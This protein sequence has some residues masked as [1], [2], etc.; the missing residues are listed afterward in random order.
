[1][2]Q[3]GGSTAGSSD[4]PVARLKT[5]QIDISL[6]EHEFLELVGDVENALHEAEVEVE[7]D[8]APPK[9]NRK[10][11]IEGLVR[12]YCRAKEAEIGA[13][14]D[15]VGPVPKGGNGDAWLAWAKKAYGWKKKQSK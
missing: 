2:G 7:G 14:V 10:R 3:V 6:G 13:L 8:K 1:M 12:D 9:T 15:A 11:I 5:V 4:L